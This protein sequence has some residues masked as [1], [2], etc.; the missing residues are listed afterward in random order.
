MIGDFVGAYFNT[1]YNAQK[2][3]REAEDEVW[4]QPDLKVQGAGKNYLAV[5]NVSQNTR[6]KFSSVIEKC[7]KLLEYHPESN[8]VDDALMMIGKSYFYQNDLSA[9]R[10]KIQGVDLRLP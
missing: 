6:T 8:L 9:C 7:S 3:F 5:F 2:A 1:Y 4:N 10:T